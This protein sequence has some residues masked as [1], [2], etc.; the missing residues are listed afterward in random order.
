MW[1]QLGFS[2][3]CI[4]NYVLDA[5]LFLQEISEVRSAVLDFKRFKWRLKQE[6][7]LLNLLNIDINICYPSRPYFMQSD[8]QASH[9]YL[10]TASS[11]KTSTHPSVECITSGSH[12]I[13]HCSWEEKDDP[14]DDDFLSFKPFHVFHGCGEHSEHCVLWVPSFPG[15]LTLG[16][17][18]TTGERTEPRGRRIRGPCA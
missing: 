5:E 12:L 3:R 6:F 7:P 8:W 14:Q 2:F 10:P 13:S 15:L 16:Q 9:R 11:D 4:F 1:L 17:V 18:D